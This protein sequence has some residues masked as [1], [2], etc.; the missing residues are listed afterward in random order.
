MT[1][2]ELL[3]KIDHKVDSLRTKNALGWYDYVTVKDY[4]ECQ[5]L[6]DTRAKIV[7]LSVSL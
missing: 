2:D 3:N 7:V 4:Q 6:L 5:I 1:V